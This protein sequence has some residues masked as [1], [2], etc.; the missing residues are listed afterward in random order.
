MKIGD[1]EVRIVAP[2]SLTLRH[3]IVAAAGSNWRRA[4]GAALGICWRGAGKPS[5]R[6]AACDYSPLKYGGEVIDELT[7]RGDDLG[8][9]MTAGG[10]AFALLTEGIITE[11]E[12][13]E[14][15]DFIE[16][17]EE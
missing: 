1:R 2:D 11:K 10:E 5:T 9:I 14:T 16:P 6:Y 12:V 3:E 15:A 7:S 17:A 13:K 8:E 4:F